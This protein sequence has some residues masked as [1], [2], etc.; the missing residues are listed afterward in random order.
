MPL[1][2]HDRDPNK[3]T[4]WPENTE[5]EMWLA[6]GFSNPISLVDFVDIATEYF[7]KFYKDFKPC[8]VS[9]STEYI[10]TCNFYYDLYN[11]SDYTHFIKLELEP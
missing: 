11:S 7:S 10:H 1:H 9:I 4:F 2:L 6:V 8:Q 3:D 5:T